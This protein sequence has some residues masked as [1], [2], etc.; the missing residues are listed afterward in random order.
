MPNSNEDRPEL[1]SLA[2]TAARN[3]LNSV[4]PEVQW[5]E[6]PDHYISVYCYVTYLVIRELIIINGGPDKNGPGSDGWIVRRQQAIHEFVKPV[7]YA[8]MRFDSDV[9]CPFGVEHSAKAW[10]SIRRIPEGQVK[11]NISDNDFDR[12]WS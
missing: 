2:Q 3:L 5:P 12:F 7:W 8:A 6:V 10:H 4:L 11:R 9:Q 1:V